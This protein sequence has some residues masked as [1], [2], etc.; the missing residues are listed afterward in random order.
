MNIYFI[1]T[2]RER[3][4]VSG[5]CFVTFPF[6]SFISHTYDIIF[7]PFLRFFS[8]FFWSHFILSGTQK[9][10]TTS[11][12]LRSCAKPSPNFIWRFFIG[13]STS[14][15]FAMTYRGKHISIP[16]TVAWG[17]FKAIYR[18][19]LLS[20][21]PISKNTCPGLSPARAW[22]LG[23]SLFLVGTKGAIESAASVK[24]MRITKKSISKRYM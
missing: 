10:Y 18:H 8:N 15:T 4:S 14:H 9:T 7:D 1:W 5:L 19:T 23:R 17:F 2:L 21:K 6:H 24:D 12:F 13:E 3:V 20:Q 11:T 22:I 16:I